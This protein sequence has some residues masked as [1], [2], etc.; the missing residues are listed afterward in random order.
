MSPC[1]L[2]VF[3]VLGETEIFNSSING[4][5]VIMQDEST[6]VRGYEN[7]ADISVKGGPALS[8]YLAHSGMDCCV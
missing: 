8:A 6:V 3:S 1:G 5:F 2:L 7:P 4:D